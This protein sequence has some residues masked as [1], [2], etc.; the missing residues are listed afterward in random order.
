MAVTVILDGPDGTGKSTL[1]EYMAKEMDAAVIHASF[2]KTWDMKNYHIILME[3]ALDFNSI[4]ISVILDRWAPSEAV[5]GPVF[6][7]DEAYDTSELISHY[8]QDRTTNLIWVYCRNDNVEENHKNNM[9]VRVEMFNRMDTVQLAFD[10]YVDSTPHLKWRVYDFNKTTPKKF[11][12]KLLR[13][14]G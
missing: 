11:V 5:Y 10:Q 6:R 14:L 3:S 7:G 9:K 4:G 13:E 8:D 1:A 12:R 2:N